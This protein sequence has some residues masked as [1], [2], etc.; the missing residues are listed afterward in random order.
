ME[1]DWNKDLEKYE[2]FIEDIDLNKY[3]HLRKIKT[4]E[5]DL[6]HELLPLDIF[7]KHYWDTTEFKDYDEVFEIYWK[8]KLHSICNFIE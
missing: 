2:K 3:A 8:E 5:Q 1:R 4:V 7:Y 6:P